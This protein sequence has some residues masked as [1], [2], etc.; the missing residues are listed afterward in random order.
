ML[1]VRRSCS[2]SLQRATETWMAGP[3]PAMTEEITPPARP[4][5]ACTPVLQRVFPASDKD[6]DGGAEPRH[7]GRDYTTGPAKCCLYAGRCSSRSYHS[8]RC[9]TFGRS[10]SMLNQRC[11]CGPQGM[12][13][14]V[15]VSPAR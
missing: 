14:K 9:G 1:L 13:A 12:S 5:A 4:D 11:R 2:A 3:S 15:S 10:K 6:V 7:D 8:R